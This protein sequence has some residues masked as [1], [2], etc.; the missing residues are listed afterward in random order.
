M[1]VEVVMVVVVE[2]TVAGPVVR[3]IMTVTIV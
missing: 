1:I 3:V 2:I